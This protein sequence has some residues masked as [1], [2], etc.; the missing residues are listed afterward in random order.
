MKQVLAVHDLDGEL[1]VSCRKC[2]GVMAGYPGGTSRYIIDGELVEDDWGDYWKCPECEY[3]EDE[4]RRDAE[5]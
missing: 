5:T 3:T 4:Q 1:K 2:G